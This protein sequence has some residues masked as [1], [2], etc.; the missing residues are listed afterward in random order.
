MI[1]SVENSV[2]A[3]QKRFGGTREGAIDWFTQHFERPELGGQLQRPEIPGIAEVARR[4]T[5]DD[6]IQLACACQ[7]SFN[8][9]SRKPSPERRR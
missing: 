8:I 3:F 5:E 7:G 1:K 6:L 4:Q 2:A 9:Y